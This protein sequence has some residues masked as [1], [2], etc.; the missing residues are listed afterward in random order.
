MFKKAIL[1]SALVLAVVV[2][3]WLVTFNHYQSEGEMTLGV[4]DEPV[5][6]RRD[7][8]GIPYIH[9]QSLADALRA[10]GFIIGQDRLYQA[11]LYK[12]IALG[13]LAELFGQRGVNSDI[14]MRTVGIT[15]IAQS[16]LELLNEDS[17]QFYQHYL[18]GL[19]AYIEEQRQEHPFSLRMLGLEPQPWT[20]RDILAV[21]YF[22]IWSSTANWRTELMAQQLI[23][24]LGAELANEIS[25]VSVNPEDE[26]VVSAQLQD[27]LQLGLRIDPDYFR[28]MPDPM[29]AASNAWASAG[30]KTASGLPIFSNSP[31]IDARTLPGFWYP[32][33]LFTP[34]L[35][36]I[37]A[38]AAGTPAFG[39]GRTEDI[40]FGATNGNSDGADLYIETLDPDRAGHYMEGDVSLPLAIREEILTVKDESAEGGFRQQTLTIRSTRRG[41]LI[42]D[43]GMALDDQRAI[44]LR[45]A[46]RDALADSLGME[47]LIVAK[48]IDEAREA[49]KKTPTPLSYIVVDRQGDIARIATGRVPKRLRGDGSR[50]FVVT[51]SSDNWDGVI[52][53]Q[54]MPTD[55]RPDRGWTGTA[56]HRLVPADYPHAYSTYFAASWRYRRIAEF[57]EQ[58]STISADDHWTLINDVKN[59]MAEKWLPIMIPVL[60]A[61]EDTAYL[62]DILSQWNLM[63][64]RDQVGAAVFQVVV[65]HFVRLTFNDEI[66]GELWKKYLDA[67]YYWQ[68]RLTLLMAD[69]HSRWFDDQSTERVETRDTQLHQAALAAVQ[70]LTA[71][72]GSN[73]DNWRW[74]SLLSITFASPVIPGETAAQWLGAGRHPMLG[75]GETLNRG[76]YKLSEGYEASYIDSTRFVAD[77]ADSEKVTAV[78]PG[79]SSGRYLDPSLHSQTNAWLAGEQHYWWFSDAAIEA[80]AVKTLRLLP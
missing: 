80:N 28:A 33:G 67:I 2:G 15:D 19:N 13:R 9:A 12:H 58:K 42:S 8:L 39:I 7:S 74:G 45:W 56:N 29:N 41:P 24:T 68:E 32:M 47:E 78:I 50:P 70:E 62:A 61:E 52:P 73:P 27:K 38:A 43:H 51:D 57:M 20:L 35:R 40:A 60:A 21:Q 63:D 36:I 53:A 69:N 5:T 10:Q 76:A 65:K 66:K 49:L 46:T 11:E 30:K 34:E 64:D 23:D 71:N 59:P 79:G 14:L 4:L 77:M 55:I 3:Y 44:S 75:S 22:Q 31:H 54:T 18:Q 6:I 48:N 72:L 25:M 1:G 26:V 17:R 37:G 16:Q